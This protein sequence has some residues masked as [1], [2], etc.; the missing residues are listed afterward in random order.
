MKQI[1]LIAG[2]ILLFTL[3]SCDQSKPEN[4]SSETAQQ[5]SIVMDGVIIGDLITNN[6]AANYKGTIDNKYAIN[7]E[8]IK[9][10]AQVGGS[11]QYDGK[12]ARLELKGNMEDTGEIRI[13]EYT[14][15]GEVSGHFE[16]KMVG[17]KITGTW[18]NE[19]R[20]K[21]MPFSLEQTS[22]ASLQTKSDILSDAMG[23]FALTS[24]SGNMGANAMFDTYKENGKWKS[25]SSGIVSG[26]R[27]GYENELT[28][29]DIALL[30]H[31][32]V[33][34]DEQLNVHVFAGLIELV[35]CPFKAGEMEYR[36]KET[37]RKKMN[38][39]IAALS[40]ESIITDNYLIL[41]ADD[42][43]DFT[44]T[45]KGEF[46]SVAADNMILLYYPAERK[47]ELDIFEG[48]CCDGNIL[49]FWVVFYKYSR[50]GKELDF[51]GTRN[52]FDDVTMLER[53]HIGEE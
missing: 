41:L 15:K 12:N 9:F 23:T 37:D 13:D 35:N 42:H 3:G 19:K 40:P 52:L 2:I 6:F 53:V 32:H 8:F 50:D 10:N 51:A 22:I 17:E 14:D 34:V 38:E 29:A 16:G 18:Y 11:Y 26:M 25:S 28:A 45:L 7:L 31:L 5:D 27:E 39:K 24:L 20:T 49:S 44:G 46:N 21:S 43:M 30:D 48:S 36:V 4:N 1:S 33:T 47:F